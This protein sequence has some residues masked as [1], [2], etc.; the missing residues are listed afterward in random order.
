MCKVFHDRSIVRY[1]RPVYHFIISSFI[2]AYCE[3]TLL[4][5]GLKR[6]CERSSEAG[7][8]RAFVEC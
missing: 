7:Y 1:A 4:T 3:S 6:N 5:V 2:I 8:L